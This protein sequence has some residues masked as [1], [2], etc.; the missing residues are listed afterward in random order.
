MCCAY[1]G[2][3]ALVGISAMTLHVSTLKVSV[4][5]PRMLKH[6]GTKV[7]WGGCGGVGNVFACCVHCKTNK[8]RCFTIVTADP[9]TA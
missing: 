8:K 1:A 3:V 9:D 2:P 7:T 6:P 4:N 5:A